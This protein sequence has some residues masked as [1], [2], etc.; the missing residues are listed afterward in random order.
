MMQIAQPKAPFRKICLDLALYDVTSEGE[1]LVVHDCGGSILAKLET[2][3]RNCWTKHYGGWLGDK[4]GAINYDSDSQTCS[5]K[6]KS[7]DAVI[8]WLTENFD[9]IDSIGYEALEDLQ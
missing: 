4:F 5:F 2:P 3:E 1:H 8:D 7:F 6:T 9:R